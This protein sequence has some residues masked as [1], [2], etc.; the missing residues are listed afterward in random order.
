[1]PADQVV[2]EARGLPRVHEVGASA[3]VDDRLRQSFVERNE[4]VAVPRDAGL[5]SERLAD[6]LAQDDGGV[7]DGV[8]CA[9]MWVS[10]VARTRRSVRECFANAVS[11]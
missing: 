1:M 10:P 2:L 4:R 9:S 7:F 5:V 3:D 6:R 8:V 11:M